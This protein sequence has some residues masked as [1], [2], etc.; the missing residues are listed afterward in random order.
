[1]EEFTNGIV[2]RLSILSYLPFVIAME[3]VLDPI[4]MQS[5]KHEKI[6]PNGGAFSEDGGV[7]TGVHKNTNIYIDDSIIL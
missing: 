6:I 1:M 2:Q 7:K 4:I 3:N 5:M